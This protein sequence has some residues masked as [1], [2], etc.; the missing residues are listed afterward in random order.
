MD[1]K[2]PRNPRPLKFDSK[3]RLDESTLLKREASNSGFLRTLIDAVK[4]ASEGDE[5]VK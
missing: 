5:K 2:S 4:L 3:N 1:L